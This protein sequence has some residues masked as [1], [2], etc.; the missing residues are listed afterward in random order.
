M[1][2]QSHTKPAGQ[3]L[4]LFRTWLG[5]RNDFLK[6]TWQQPTPFFVNLFACEG[7]GEEASSSC[8]CLKLYCSQ[9]RVRVLW[10][11]VNPSMWSETAPEGDEAQHRQCSVTT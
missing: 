6:P 5:Q 7:F 4:L 1:V 9:I 10:S 3:L 11:A 2:S 8:Q